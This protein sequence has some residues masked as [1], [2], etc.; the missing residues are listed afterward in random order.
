MLLNVEELFQ[1]PVVL[2]GHPS[3]DMGDIGYT[4][5]MNEPIPI[6]II[7]PILVIVPA[8]APFN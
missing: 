7:I 3:V 4:L 8:N 1:I 2:F 5:Y 6:H